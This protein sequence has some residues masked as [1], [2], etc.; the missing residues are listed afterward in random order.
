MPKGRAREHFV[1]GSVLGVRVLCA[2]RGAVRMR[3]VCAALS[4]RRDRVAYRASLLLLPACTAAFW[5]LKTFSAR[6][7]ARG[8]ARRASHQAIQIT[9]ALPALPPTMGPAG[10]CM[11]AANSQTKEVKEIVRQHPAEQGRC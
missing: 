5:F 1:V 6:L 3:S 10:A 4:T 7:C 2:P 8:S 11:L 9:H